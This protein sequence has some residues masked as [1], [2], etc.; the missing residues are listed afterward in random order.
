MSGNFVATHLVQMFG[1]I[2]AA[3]SFYHY[4]S[5][6][7]VKDHK[8]SMQEIS[9]EAKMKY[10]RSNCILENKDGKERGNWKMFKVN[11]NCRSGHIFYLVHQSNDTLPFSQGGLV[12]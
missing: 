4:S 9:I 5:L 11:K 1:E 8:E 6:T 10:K 12:A 2:N 7:A 3:F